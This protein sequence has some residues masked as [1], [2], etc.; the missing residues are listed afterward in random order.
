MKL[1]LDT[2]IITFIIKGQDDE[3]DHNTWELISDAENLLYTSPICIN[4]LIH[5][6][7][8]GRVVRGREWNRDVSVLK[9]IEDFGIEIA[10]LSSTHLEQVERL[11][12]VDRH[13]DPNDRLIIAQAISDK[14]TLVSSDLQFPKYRKYGLKLHQNK[15]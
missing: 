15:R 14:A 12:I 6:I 1:Y 3:I 7:Q 10:P 2:N 13:N 8:N 5:L 11:P 4:E 9:R